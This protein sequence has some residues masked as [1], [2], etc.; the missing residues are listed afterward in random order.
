MRD[1]LDARD[2]RTPRL[3]DPDREHRHLAAELAVRRLED[4]AIAVAPRGRPATAEAHGDSGPLRERR[5]VALH[6]RSRRVVRAAIH[7]RGH[8]RGVLA[9]DGQQAV[10]VVALVL[11]CAALERRVRLRPR[12]QPLE[13]RPAPEHAAG[14]LVR[15]DHGVADAKTRERVADLKA[16]G[17][18]AHD[19]DR[20]LARWVRPVGQPR[21]RVAFAS[22]RASATRIL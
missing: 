12:E 3:R 15:R 10:P 11:A 6:L 21:P 17:S 4:P 8:Q 16:A 18:A 14:T 9:L 22:L 5:E 20:V 19:D 7:D 2:L 1:V 13:E